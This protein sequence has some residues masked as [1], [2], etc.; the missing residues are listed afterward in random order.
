MKYGGIGTEYPI[1]C[2]LSRVLTKERKDRVV[3]M[4]REEEW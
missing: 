2:D 4:L 1:I 3:A